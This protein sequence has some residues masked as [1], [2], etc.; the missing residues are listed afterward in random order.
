[1]S[2]HEQLE[3]LNQELGRREKAGD[4]EYFAKL[5]TDGFIFR[6]ANGVLVGKS[7]FIDGLATVV[8]NPYE[9]SDTR[10]ENVTVNGASAVVHAIVIAKRRNME[11]PG[12]FENVRV[13]RQEN[14]E[15]R[16]A[17]WV[18]TKIRDLSK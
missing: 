2:E 18:N 3:Q 9:Q 16:L 6:R 4:G 13:F 12:E 5:L 17:I 14:D 7:A 11:H 1:M 8:E 10:I 15:W